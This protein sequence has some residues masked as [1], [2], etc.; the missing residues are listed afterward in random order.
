MAVGVVCPSCGRTGAGKSNLITMLDIMTQEVYLQED[1]YFFKNYWWNTK[2][3]PAPDFFDELINELHKPVEESTRVGGLIETN[4][5]H[6]TLRGFS[7]R[8]ITTM[9]ILC[10]IPASAMNYLSE[11]TFF[12][13]PSNRKMPDYNWLKGAFKSLRS[14]YG[15]WFNKEKNQYDDIF[16]E[17]VKQGRNMTVPTQI[18][19]DYLLDAEKLVVH[20][21]NEFV[22]K[23][24]EQRED[25][26]TGCY[27]KEWVD[28][29]KKKF[30]PFNKG[31][32]YFQEFMKDEHKNKVEQQALGSII[33]ETNTLIKLIEEKTNGKWIGK[34]GKEETGNTKG[35]LMPGSKNRWTGDTSYQLFRPCGITKVNENRL[36]IKLERDLIA[37]WY[38][39]LLDTVACWKFQTRPMSR[40]L[41]ENF[42][43][44]GNPLQSCVFCPP[45]NNTASSPDDYFFDKHVLIGHEWE[46]DGTWNPD[47]WFRNARNIEITNHV[48]WVLEEAEPIIDTLLKDSTCDDK[49]LE[50]FRSALDMFAIEFAKHKGN[51]VQ[52]VKRLR[53]LMDKVTEEQKGRKRYEKQIEATKELEIKENE[54]KKKTEES[55]NDLKNTLSNIQ[56]KMSETKSDYELQKLKEDLSDANRDIRD[57]E[58]KIKNHEEELSRLRTRIEEVRRFSEQRL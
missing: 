3:I 22:H 36:I 34:D 57:K 6:F 5:K 18:Q 7:Y 41:I 33:H 43:G 14:H 25:K 9:K 11:S 19:R 17:L 2:M 40:E 46:K 21:L 35:R 28:D 15:Y 55:L 27:R 56:K 38:P 42:N 13:Y 49:S 45:H 32:R 12:L 4:L 52:E 47:Q 54:E 53:K 8:W 39:R 16:D 24:K 44:E 1:G 50:K 31:G 58:R 26:T 30:A 20:S 37:E 29:L 51:D 10:Y 48:A 23:K